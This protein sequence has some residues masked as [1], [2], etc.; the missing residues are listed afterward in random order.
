MNK[1]EQHG[2]R[3]RQPGRVDEGKKMERPLRITLGVQCRLGIG[4]EKGGG[5]Q[6]ERLK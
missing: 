3:G 4:V 1:Q 2:E 5:E 6:L